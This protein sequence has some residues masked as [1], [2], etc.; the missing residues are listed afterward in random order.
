[1]VP[2]SYYTSSTGEIG[3]EFWGRGGR[4]RHSLASDLFDM[5]SYYKSCKLRV[6]AKLA[7]PQESENN[8]QFKG[9]ASLT[10]NINVY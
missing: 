7:L 4:R 10:L 1:M 8:R 5:L 2:H 6:I 9:D 3:V